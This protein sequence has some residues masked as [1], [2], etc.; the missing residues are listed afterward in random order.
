MSTIS[1]MIS[2]LQMRYGQ[3]GVPIESGALAPTL[4]ALSFDFY[5]F[6]MS[7]SERIV[8]VVEGSCVEERAEN[9]QVE[10][11]VIESSQEEDSSSSPEI[12]ENEEDSSSS[13]E[14][15]ENEEEITVLPA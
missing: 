11:T 1:V 15:N 8:L 3:H 10:E 12:D 14:I 2:A 13:P 9:N 5:P 6:P 7:D 4:L